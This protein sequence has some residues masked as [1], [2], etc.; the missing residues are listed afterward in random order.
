MPEGATMIPKAISTAGAKL[1]NPDHALIMIDFPSQMSFAT[2][3]FAGPRLHGW[4]ADI[5]W[6]D[7]R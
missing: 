5:C 6:M 3:S 7:Q 4:P 2:R 1:I